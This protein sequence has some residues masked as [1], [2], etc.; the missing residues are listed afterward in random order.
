MLDDIFFRFI[1][2]NKVIPIQK[3]RGER[4]GEGRKNDKFSRIRNAHK[5]LFHSIVEFIAAI[6]Y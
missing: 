4:R 5:V 6:I 1:G 2:E 3:K